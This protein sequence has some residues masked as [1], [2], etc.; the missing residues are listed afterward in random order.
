MPRRSAC[1]ATALALTLA[2][3]PALAQKQLSLIHI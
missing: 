2:T 1:L 3:V